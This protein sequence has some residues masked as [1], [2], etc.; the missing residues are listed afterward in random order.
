M[1]T[2]LL[3]TSAN[4][5]AARLFLWARWCERASER[6]DGKLRSPPADLSGAC[7]FAAVF[8]QLVFGGELAGN[9]YHL[10]CVSADGQRIDLTEGVQFA[11]GIPK[12][13][14]ARAREVGLHVSDIYKHDPRVWAQPEFV[15]AMASVNERAR[16]WAQAFVSQIVA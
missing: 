12:D 3:P 15:A 13:L 14:E 7:R 10:H 9:W 5:A 8:A 16:S 2:P 1:R 6:A 4:L 11:A